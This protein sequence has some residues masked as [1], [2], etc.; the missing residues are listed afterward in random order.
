MPVWSSKFSESL[1][2]WVKKHGARRFVY[3]AVIAFFA[4][5]IATVRYPPTQQ[6]KNKSQ[7]NKGKSSQGSLPVDYR[8]GDTYSSRNI[9]VELKDS[10]PVVKKRIEELVGKSTL[11]PR[12]KI[13]AAKSDWTPDKKQIYTYI[14]MTVK[15][16]LKGEEPAKQITIKQL[17]GR[18]GEMMLYVPDAPRLQLGEDVVLMLKRWDSEYVVVGLADGKFGVRTDPEGRQVV[19]NDRLSNKPISFEDFKKQV[20]N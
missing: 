10:N 11:V 4:I 14:T 5:V 17:G 8:P 16:L 20:T 2:L 7:N 15:E 13:V 6:E 9:G 1:K 18:V 19:E 12:G 3:V